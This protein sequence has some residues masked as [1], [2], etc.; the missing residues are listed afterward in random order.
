MKSGPTLA[1]ATRRPRR[2]NAAISPVATVVLPTPECVPAMTTHAVLTSQPCEPG[3]NGPRLGVVAERDAEG[4]AGFG[5]GQ[6]VG[7]DR[8]ARGP[9]AGRRSGARG[10]D[11]RYPTGDGV[12]DRAFE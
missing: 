1:D 11:H 4:D 5:G 9:R 6:P 10:D 7:V 12:V 3:R 2:R 8:P